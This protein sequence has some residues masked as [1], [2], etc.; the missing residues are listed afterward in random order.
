MYYDLKNEETHAMP[1]MAMKLA[2]D[3]NRSPTPISEVIFNRRPNGV[4]INVD[5][6]QEVFDKRVRME[7]KEIRIYAI[8]PAVCNPFISRTVSF[9]YVDSSERIGPVR[10][11]TLY[12]DDLLPRWFYSVEGGSLE[13]LASQ[14]KEDIEHTVP[15]YGNLKSPKIN[16]PVIKLWREPSFVVRPANVKGEA[17]SIFQKI[18]EK[19]SYSALHRD[20]SVPSKH[21][22]AS[23]APRGDLDISEIN[24]CIRSIVME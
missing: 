8:K 23:L 7:S 2:S 10:R 1:N 20:F 22:L 5:N 12:E 9:C 19:A 21:G 11:I 14:M 18:L 4:M 3:I 17:S 16:Y 15:P 13:D 6:P 24:N